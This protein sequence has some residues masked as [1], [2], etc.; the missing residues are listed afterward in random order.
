LPHPLANR[1]HARV[2]AK[3]A[4]TYPP[5]RERSK[6]RCVSGVSRHPPVLGAR[7]CP[8]RAGMIRCFG[9]SA[10]PGSRPEI[11][12]DSYPPKPGGQVSAIIQRTAAAS[13]LWLDVRFIGPAAIITARSRDAPRT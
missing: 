10:D 13:E 5:I 8:V 11:I 4:D 1:H 7:R 2:P 3:I 9:A 6:L 12:A